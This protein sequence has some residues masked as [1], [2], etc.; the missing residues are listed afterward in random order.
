MCAVN[1]RNVWFRCTYAKG[2]LLKKIFVLIFAI[3]VSFHSSSS[4]F[5]NTYFKMQPLIW[6]LVCV[7]LV[8]WSIN[9][10]KPKII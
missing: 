4:F 10:S 8:L 5:G 1:S 6:T 2:E 9:A 7:I 3:S